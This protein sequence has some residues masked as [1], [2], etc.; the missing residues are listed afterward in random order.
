MDR[1]YTTDICGLAERVTSSDA[2]GETRDESQDLLIAVESLRQMLA[3]PQR[4]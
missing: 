4:P 3:H 1:V 2:S